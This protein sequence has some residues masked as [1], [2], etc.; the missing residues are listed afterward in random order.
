MDTQKDPLII[1]GST[2]SALMLYSG[3]FMRYALAVTPKNYLLFAC[4]FV[5]F[6]GQGTQLYRWYDYWYMGGQAKWDTLR[7]DAKAAEGLVD[8]TQQKVQGIAEEVKNKVS[9]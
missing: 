8:Q 6:G 7:A 1:S 9:K 4:H 5:N 2:T 3:T